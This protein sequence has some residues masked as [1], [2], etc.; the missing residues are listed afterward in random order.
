MSNAFR[1]QIPSSV[2]ADDRRSLL[3]RLW[4]GVHL[5][6]P[7]NAGVL[8]DAYEFFTVGNVATV[9]SVRDEFLIPADISIIDVSGNDHSI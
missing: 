8:D 5:I 1:L 7:S 6:S 9:D 2:S 3:N 4:N